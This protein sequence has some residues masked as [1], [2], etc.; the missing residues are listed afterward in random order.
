MSAPRGLLR[1]SLVWGFGSIPPEV[2]T[3]RCHSTLTSGVRPVG[4]EGRRGSV[5]TAHLVRGTK[6]GFDPLV[7]V[8]LPFRDPCSTHSS[9]GRVGGTAG[10]ATDT[11]TTRVREGETGETPD[12]GP[13]GW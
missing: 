3:F 9:W 8:P 5:V 12:S 4:V 11:D 7:P 10:G 2:E 6:E 13:S 1:E